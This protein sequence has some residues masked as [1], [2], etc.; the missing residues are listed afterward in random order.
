MSKVVVNNLDV[1]LGNLKSLSEKV[2]KQL[3]ASI[4]EVSEIMYETLY[5]NCTLAEIDLEALGHPYRIGGNPPDMPKIHTQSGKLASSI[6]KMTQLSGDKLLVAVFIQEADV[7]YIK[8]VVEGTSY[9]IPRPVFDYTWQQ[10]K[11]TV[12]AMIKSGIASSTSS[13]G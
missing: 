11:T 7:P 3:D 5:K 2:K 10:V 4:Q 8:Y 6:K 12:L 13:R 1:V 9:L